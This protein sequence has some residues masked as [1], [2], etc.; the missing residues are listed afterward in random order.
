MTEYSRTLDSDCSNLVDTRCLVG[1]DL[2]R[3]DS[4]ET[5]SLNLWGVDIVSH[6]S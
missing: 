6:G 4:D 1:S 5:L 2:R 3:I